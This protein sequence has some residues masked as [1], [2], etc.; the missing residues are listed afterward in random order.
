MERR[1]ALA[2]AKHFWIVVALIA[3]ASSS[4]Q[5]EQQSNNTAQ[6]SPSSPAPAVNHASDQNKPG[7]PPLSY[8][9][10]IEKA[11]PAVVTIRSE[12]RV[13][14]PRQFPFFDN[15]LFRDFF[16]DQ[17]PQS[18]SNRPQVQM[19]LGSGVI[20]HAD[21]TIL[22]NHHV[23]D[24]AEQIKVELPNHRI[25]DAKVVGSDPPSDL[26]VLKIDAK[27][28]PVLAL[29]DSDKVR[30]GDIALAIGNPLG[31]GQ[32]VTAGIISAKSRY[33]GLSD[34][35]FEDFLQTDAPIN[36]GNSGGALIDSTGE[37]IGINSQI[38]STSGG[39]IGI[40]FAIPSNMAR[41]VMDQLSKTGKVHRGQLGIAIQPMTPELAKQFGLSETRGV[42]VN[43]MTENGP[44]AKAGIRRG[45]VIVAFNG[46]PVTDGNTLRNQIAGTAPG[47]QVKLTI[48]RDKREQEIPVTLGEYQ[49]RA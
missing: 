30:V 16:G 42:L 14:A 40:G 7:G 6:S 1:F 37:L 33:T 19:A 3:L 24:G 23:V 25:F 22:T 20:V 26:A 18:R 13:R 49:P 5:K 28:L 9:D 4:C 8:A 41:N 15:P 32:T 2:L 31:I 10:V 44:A 11:G 46:K 36:Q 35:S 29:G 38:L 27:D 12:R 48:V 45:D 47:T 21:G 39:N 43:G 34:G 17:G